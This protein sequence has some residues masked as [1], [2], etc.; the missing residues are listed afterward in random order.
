MGFEQVDEACQAG[1]RATNADFATPSGT[2]GINPLKTA[3]RNIYVPF[4]LSNYTSSGLSDS[5][6]GI[7]QGV[8]IP[9]A[10]HYIYLSAMAPRGEIDPGEKGTLHILWNTSSTTGVV[11]FVADIRP[12]IEGSVSLV[13]AVSRSVIQAANGTTNLISDAKIIFPV[14]ILNKAQ[15]WGLKISRDG[16]NS[17]DTIGATIAI[18]S[19][20]MEILGR[21]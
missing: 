10:A 2:A 19:V 5:Q 9:D 17:L 8:A 21:C 14:A 13:S 4:I 11:R 1:A 7:M 15:G 6:A 12:I 20:H 18:R 3:K 16:T